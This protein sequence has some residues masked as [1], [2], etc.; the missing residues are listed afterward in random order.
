MHF[1]QDWHLSSH[2]GIKILVDEV[3]LRWSSLFTLTV[4]TAHVCS[5]CP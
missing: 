2:Y 1:T 3:L 5:A 4:W